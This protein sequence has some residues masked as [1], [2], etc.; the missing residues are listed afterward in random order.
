MAE[1]GILILKQVLY[2]PL[3]EDEHLQR[4]WELKFLA[5]QFK[6]EKLTGLT[7][8]L[9][10]ELIVLF[11]IKHLAQKGKAMPNAISSKHYERFVPNSLEEEAEESREH[12]QKLY[13]THKGRN[14]SEIDQLIEARLSVSHMFRKYTVEMRVVEMS[15]GLT[16]SKKRLKS[17]VV[18]MGWKGLVILSFNE[19]I[20]MKGS[21]DYLTF[22]LGSLGLK[23]FSD[24][25]EIILKCAQLY[26]IY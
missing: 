7:K 12:I 18:G 16:S 21:W 24:S 15:E 8:D 23:I 22:C 2:Y 3:S 6:E 4:E 14:P 13:L 20:I 10:F 1:R 9:R 19:R 17:V 11:T 5:Y 26:E 25:Q